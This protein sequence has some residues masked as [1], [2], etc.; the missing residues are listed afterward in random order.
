MGGS[1][2]NEVVGICKGGGGGNDTCMADRGI[3]NGY[4]RE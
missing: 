3:G 2:L 1:K 4:R